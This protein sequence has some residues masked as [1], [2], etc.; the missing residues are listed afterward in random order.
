M[1]SISKFGVGGTE[2]G[3]FIGSSMS[4]VTRSEKDT[5][6]DKSKSDALLEFTMDEEVFKER[7]SAEGGAGSVYK[8]AVKGRLPIVK[9]GVRHRQRHPLLRV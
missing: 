3:F 8:D 7:W 5:T 9:G 2:A 6:T 4:I 1:D